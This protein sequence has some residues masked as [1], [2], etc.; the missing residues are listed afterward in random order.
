MLLRNY[1]FWFKTLTLEK[2]T[3]LDN[4]SGGDFR[5][6]VYFP[7][8]LGAMIQFD[9]HLF[10]MGWLKH[11]NGLSTTSLGLDCAIGMKP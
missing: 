7:P 6:F 4:Y 3:F 5:D 8:L 11:Q 9:E 10:Q 1:L 2:K